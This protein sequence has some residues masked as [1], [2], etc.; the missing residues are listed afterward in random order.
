MGDRQRRGPLLVIQGADDTVVPPLLATRLIA[1]WTA[2]HDLVDV[3]LLNHSLKLAET[4]TA[5]PPDR[6]PYTRTTFAAADGRSV[7][8]SYLIE[9]RGHVWP[10]PAGDGLCTDHAGPDTSALTWEFAKRNPMVTSR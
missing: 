3:S 6:Y 1:H 4:T 2:V 5:T 8:E 10:G 7:I 9:G